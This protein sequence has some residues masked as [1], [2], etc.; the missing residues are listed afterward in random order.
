MMYSS[1]IGFVNMA[2][3]ALMGISIC[4][5]AICWRF[6][7]KDGKMPVEKMTLN[8]VGTMMMANTIFWTYTSIAQLIIIYSGNTSH[9]QTWYLARG[10]GRDMA[11]SWQYVAVALILLGF[12]VPFLLLLQRPLKQRMQTLG[13]I[14]LLVFLMRIV[15]VIWWVVPSGGH[16]YEGF[17]PNS[18]HWVDFAAILGLGGIWLS[19]FFYFLSGRRVLSPTTEPKPGHGHGSHSHSHAHAPVG[20]QVVSHA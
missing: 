16:I 4:I 1:I 14:A 12:L 10:F 9:G 8:D 13:A 20:G 3:Q 7:R 17:K 6:G 15:D 5:F 19:G 2:S 11:N 18:I